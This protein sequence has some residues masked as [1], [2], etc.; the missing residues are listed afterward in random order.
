MSG[1]LYLCAT[2]IGN[3]EDIT[4]RAVRLLNEV[5]LIA[6]EDTRNSIKL[7]NYYNIKTPMTSYHE[8]NKYDKAGRLVKEMLEGKNIA[9]ITDAGMPGISDP[10]E[11]LVKAAYAAGVEVTALPGACAA[12]TALALSGLASRRFTFEAFLPSNKKERKAALEALKMDEKTIIIYEAPHR[13]AKTVN[14]LYEAFGARKASFCKELTKFY[15]NVFMTDLSEAVRHYEENP[16]K[17]EYVIIIEG[18]S[19]EDKLAKERERWLG[20]SVEEHVNHYISEGM[21]KKEAMK[22]AAADRGA[23]KRDIYNSMIQKDI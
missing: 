10:G 9:L 1:K 5:D 6:A 19:R 13:L 17:G 23:A 21:D 2:P 22:S 12:V 16:P 20:M 8:H 18:R 3:I 14:E 4:F 7:L 15:E 11:E